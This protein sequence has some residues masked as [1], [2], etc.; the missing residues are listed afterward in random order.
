MAAA[1]QGKEKHRKADLKSENARWSLA[2]GTILAS[3]V[4]HVK[5]RVIGP[6]MKV[7]SAL[8]AFGLIATSSKIVTFDNAAVGKAPPGWTVAMT[9]HGG[10]A[11]WEIRLDR[12]AP[13]QPYV[14]AQLSDEHRGGCYPM[15]ILDGVTLRDGDVSVRVKPV[16][17]HEDRVGGV[18]FRYRDA[19]NYYLAR[20]NALGNSIA[21]FKVEN[22]QRYQI[23]RDVQHDV[24]S[25]AWSILKISA[26]GNRFQVYVNHRRILQTVDNTFSGPGQV[27]LWTAGDAVTY[28]D[29]F[30]VYPR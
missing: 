11:K 2:P 14:L 15:A 30:R 9:N 26:R 13:T 6:R 5:K 17:G 22:G 19:N 20:A 25:G 21:I 23:S 7:F 10:A 27:G 3:R 29:D 4:L 24:P 8:A 16:G 12:T 18:V 1:I 28:F